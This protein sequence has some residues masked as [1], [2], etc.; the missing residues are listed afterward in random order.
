MKTFVTI[1]FLLTI[2]A[3]VASCTYNIRVIH[4]EGTTS[5]LIDDVSTSTPT[6]STSLD[7]DKKI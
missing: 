6:I 1:V 3:F 2:L 7:L 4:T 5:D